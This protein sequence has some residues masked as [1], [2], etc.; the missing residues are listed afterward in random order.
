MAYI[1]FVVALF[2]PS[3]VGVLG[4]KLRRT[5]NPTHLI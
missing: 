4:Q 2:L 5:N 1:G 3:D